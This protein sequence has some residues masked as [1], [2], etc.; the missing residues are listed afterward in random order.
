MIFPDFVIPSR[1]NQV[2]QTTGMDSKELCRDLQHYQSYPHQIEYRYNDRGYRD[3]AWP[4]SLRVLRDAVWC[5]GDSFTV[6]IG[7]PRSHTWTYLL[8]QALGQ[9]T[10]NV[11]MDGASNNW[12]ARRA[13]RVIKHLAP[14][15]MILHW[16]YVN[17]READV[18][19]ELDKTWQEFYG[20]VRAAGWPECS[21]QDRHLL[22]QHIQQELN[23]L[24]SK[25]NTDVPDDYRLIYLTDCT[26]EDDIRNTLDCIHSVN[27]AATSTRVIHSFVPNF[28]PDGFKGVIESQMSDLVITE[29][30]ILDLARDGHHYDIATAKWLVDQIQR[31]L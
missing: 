11:S 9:R 19:I 6:G 22:P 10:I 7:S 17:R 20:N 8:Q 24:H 4:D 1:A 28:V 13:I 30:P 12:I 14:E 15:V 25:F 26:D 29:T 31:L 27:Q 2:W 21:R 3:D 23:Q 18:E 16:S 5:I